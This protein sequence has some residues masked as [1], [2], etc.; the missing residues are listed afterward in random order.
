[1]VNSQV[2]SSRSSA[3]MPAPFVT[4]SLRLVSTGR[5]LGR[6]LDDLGAARAPCC[7]YPVPP[8][9]TASPRTLSIGTN[10]TCGLPRGHPYSAECVEGVFCEVRTPDRTESHSHLRIFMRHHNM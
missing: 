1:M 2:P 10:N 9:R 8:H 5:L 6:L 7:S 4:D 3:L